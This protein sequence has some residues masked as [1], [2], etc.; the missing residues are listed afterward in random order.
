MIYAGIGSRQT[1]DD[2]I[3]KMIALG[4]YMAEQGH[5]LRSG[6]ADGADHA[7]EHGCDNAGGNKEIW[8][9]WKGFNGSKST[10]ILANLPL[11]SIIRAEAIAAKLHPAWDRC[12]PPARRLHARNVLQ[13]LGGDFKTPVERVLCWTPR[14]EVVGGTAT[15]LKLAKQCDIEIVNFGWIDAAAEAL[16]LPVSV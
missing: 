13:V 11:L 2:V 8:L 12:M 7:F 15:A 10:F 6:G 3:D 5:L 1:P 4:K 14:G 9:P 16:Q